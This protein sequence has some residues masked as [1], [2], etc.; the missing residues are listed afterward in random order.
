LALRASVFVLGSGHPRYFGGAVERVVATDQVRVGA[1]GACQAFGQELH[2][3]R[4]TEQ[5]RHRRGQGRIVTDQEPAGRSKR[6][7]ELRVELG[8]QDR[9]VRR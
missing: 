8:G 9:P 6:G 1:A 5:R 4:R 2:R 3:R 7:V